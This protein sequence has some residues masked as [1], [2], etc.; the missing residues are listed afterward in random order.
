MSTVVNGH[1]HTVCV[2]PA[3]LALPPAEGL[4]FATSDT[5]GHSHMMTLTQ[6]QLKT[7]ASGREV[8]VQTTTVQLHHHEF[9]LVTVA[10][11]VAADT[12]STGT[13]GGGAGG[14]GGG[15]GY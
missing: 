9:V 11:S 6:E 12:Q 4:T 14:T 3:D 7:I 13:D 10:S 2:A 15:R 8:T 5:D 1:S